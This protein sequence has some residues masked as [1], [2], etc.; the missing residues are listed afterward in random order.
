MSVRAL[1]Q[2]FEEN[3]K[4]ASSPPTSPPRGKGAKPPLRI[5]TPS[6]Q[7]EDEIR[8]SA[9]SAAA[10]ASQ[11]AAAANASRRKQPPSA[12]FTPNSAHTFGR[13]N[14]SLAPPKDSGPQSTLST[15]PGL[16]TVSASPS[17]VNPTPTSSLPT[18]PD[19]AALASRRAERYNR[20]EQQLVA[21]ATP[22]LPEFSPR[23]LQKFELARA[24]GL[25]TERAAAARARVVELREQLARHDLDPEEH[26]ALQQERWKQER[27]AG[28]AEQQLARIKEAEAI[29]KEKTPS[30]S[31]PD[32]ASFT[33]NNDQPTTAI[34]DAEARRKTNLVKFF[35][36]SPTHVTAHTRNRSRVMILTSH[37]AGRD[38][39]ELQLRDWPIGA[40]LRRQSFANLRPRSLDGKDRDTPPAAERLGH[41]SARKKS[42]R[43]PPALPLFDDATSSSTEQEWVHSAPAHTA[44]TRFPRAPPLHLLD[45]TPDGK[46]MVYART[47]LPTREE[48]LAGV[49]PDAGPVDMPSYV[50]ALLDEFDFDMPDVVSA[51]ALPKPEPIPVPAPKISRASTM[52]TATTRPSTTR[53]STATSMRLSTASPPM[54]PAHTPLPLLTLTLSRRASVE[55]LGSAVLVSR[56]SIDSYH[57]PQQRS[58]RLRFS[59]LR[60]SMHAGT[61][62]SVGDGSEEGS[63]APRMRK[64]S[65]LRPRTVS[66]GEDGQGVMDRVRKRVSVLGKR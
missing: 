22:D 48:I 56:P 26:T 24:Q 3:D 61:S 41:G 16:S 40:S 49:Q 25:L 38:T 45:E 8:A 66:S 21:A 53:M 62:S 14:L 1:L 35:A 42:R 65:F 7:S 46:A 58:S 44:I 63:R 32:A 2:A 34:T 59:S 64:P 4:R 39:L 5:N 23:T 37:P 55:T 9:A 30:T 29:L 19:T 12:L 13:P 17:T 60:S 28:A 50:S 57:Y 6:L 47:A 31:P 51:L 43:V 15:G 33:V 27:W 36:Q 18:P 20:D 54:L 10:Q 11:A 52:R